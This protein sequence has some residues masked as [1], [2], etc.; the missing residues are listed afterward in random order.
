MTD[1]AAIQALHAGP[2][3][4]VL[5]IS[6]G[7]SQ[8]IS[9]LLQVPG[10]SNTLLEAVVPYSHAALSDW[11]GGEPESFCSR[12]TA[13]SMATVA[14]HRARGLARRSGLADD[15]CLGVACTA[16]LG[17]AEPKRGEHRCW[18]AVEC[19][20][21]SR[22]RSLILTKGARDRAGEEELVAD[23]VVSTLGTV[24]GCEAASVRA[25]L[26]GEQVVNEN[27]S[28]P[29]GIRAV[30]NGSASVIWSLPDGQLSSTG[31][32]DGPLLGILS[33]SFDPLHA[34]HRELRNVAEELLNGSVCFE[35]PIRN[36]DKPP[37]GAA[38]IESRRAQFDEHSLALSAAP[39]F[40]DKAALFPGVTFVIGYDTAER[41][42]QPRFYGGSESVMRESF[43][44][45][46]DAGCRF[47][48]A[49]RQSGGVFETLDRL[50]VPDGLRDLFDAIPEERF[51]ADISATRLRR[52]GEPQ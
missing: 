35:L 34:G 14:W 9:D 37:L 23:L 24:T 5:A 45:I 49:G 22:I 12:E 8:A 48:V 15:D 31:T 27:I 52:S 25:L 32:A 40:V 4:M 20:E 18:I 7:G 42:I 44:T 39:L 21:G 16:S 1:I 13:L 33:G 17:S 38:S 41:I 29:A 28:L 30:R 3:R 11:L 36:A 51:R 2:H 6:G 50:P 10:A 26:A 46:R 19:S 43:N 47:L